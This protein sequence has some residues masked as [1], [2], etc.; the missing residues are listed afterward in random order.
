MNPADCKSSSTE[1]SNLNGAQRVCEVQQAQL[2]QPA[3]P[4]GKGK[5]LVAGREVVGR[6]MEIKHGKEWV[7]GTVMD[8]NSQLGTHRLRMVDSGRNRYISG[9]QNP[10]S[11]NLSACPSL[12]A[13]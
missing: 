5:F 1:V 7:T 12:S 4:A 6:K 11:C 2:A 3:Q 10:P 9:E 13:E 8:F